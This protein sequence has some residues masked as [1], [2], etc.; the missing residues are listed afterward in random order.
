LRDRITDEI[1]AVATEY[2][3]L[4]ILIA[5]VIIGAVTTFGFVLGDKYEQA[6]CGAFASE[7]P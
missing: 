7:C 1:G 5:V 2:V 4:L 6:T 3:L